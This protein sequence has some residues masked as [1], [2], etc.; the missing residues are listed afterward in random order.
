MSQAV[1]RSAGRPAWRL[2]GTE[3]FRA[4]AEYLARWREHALQSLPRGDG[5]PV[6][7]FPV[8]AALAARWRRCASNVVRRA[9]RRW[10]GN[11]VET[12][13][14]AGTTM[15]GWM[16]WRRAKLLPVRQVITIGTPFNGQAAQTHAGWLCRLLNGVVAWQTC[17]H[18]R[19]GALAQDV[20]VDSCHLGLG[21]NIAVMQVVA[22][23]L[24]LPVGNGGR[25]AVQPDKIR[26]D[27]RAETDK[28]DICRLTLCQQYWVWARATSDSWPG[29]LL[30]GMPGRVS[31]QGGYLLALP[32]PE[33]PESWEEDDEAPLLRPV[34]APLRE[35]VGE[36][37]VAVL[38]PLAIVVVEVAHL[39]A[40]PLVV[41]P[42]EL[43]AADRPCPRRHGCR[44]RRRSRS[45]L[46]AARRDRGSARR[47]C[48]PGPNDP[49]RRTCRRARRR[50]NRRSPSGRSG[51]RRHSRRSPALSRRGR[52]PSDPRRSRPGRLV[53]HSPAGRGRA[54]RPG[55]PCR[56][57]DAAAVDR[58]RTGRLGAIRSNTCLAVVC[59]HRVAC[60]LPL[61]MRF[62]L[63]WPARRQW[64]TPCPRRVFRGARI[65]I[66]PGARVPLWS[67]VAIEHAAQQFA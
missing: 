5:H 56:L 63:P 52:T 62:R 6:V 31:T 8:W 37:L 11:V 66:R 49:V 65:D 20:E 35:L 57:A 24:A 42:V 19:G 10:I 41:V 58:Q 34:L 2:L 47:N 44:S 3:P 43:R 38:S 26:C 21:W 13:A 15:S 17:R 54:S 25:T 39:F 67:T 18:V 12:S 55:H 23:R 36:L 32:E 40:A 28:S 61:P 30:T 29:R 22:D 7:L 50:H 27:L 9:I 60:L 16:R 4:R 59:C 48:C 45:R 1:I 51:A 53:H 46:G 33:L 64:P 14:P